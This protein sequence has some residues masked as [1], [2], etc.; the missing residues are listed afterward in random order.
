MSLIKVEVGETCAH[1]AAQRLL[2][3]RSAGVYVLRVYM[4][5]RLESLWPCVAV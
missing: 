2:K 4:F 1:P 5:G 3:R